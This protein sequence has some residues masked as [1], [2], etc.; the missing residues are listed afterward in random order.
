MGRC[1]QLME[2]DRPELFAA[3]IAE[4]DDLMEFEVVPV[5][6]SSEAAAVAL[7]RRPE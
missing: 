1:F 5:I 6:S 7:G 2:A 4:W 3:W